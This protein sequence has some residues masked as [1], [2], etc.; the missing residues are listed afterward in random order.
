MEGAVTLGAVAAIPL[1]L[2]VFVRVFP[3]L[4]IWEMEEESVVVEPG[5]VPGA[6]RELVPARE[7]V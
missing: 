2:M 1:L 4:S 6:V 5:E 3:I 7:V